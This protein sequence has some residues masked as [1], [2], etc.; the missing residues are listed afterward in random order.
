MKH[1]LRTHG[2]RDVSQA[3]IS[4]SETVRPLLPFYSLDEL[5]LQ[6]RV[7]VNKCDAGMLDA[8]ELDVGVICLRR[9]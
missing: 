5:T 3:E 9:K 7:L 1:V 6:F 4:V 2:D 8:L